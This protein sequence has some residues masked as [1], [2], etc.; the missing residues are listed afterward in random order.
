MVVSAWGQQQSPAN[1]VPNPGFE[2]FAHPPPEWYYNGKDFSRT[3]KYWSSPTGA[4]PDAYGPAVVVPGS[5][6]EKGF[7]DERPRSGQ[8][9]A[10]I[11]VYG[12]D[13][14]KPHC[15]EYLQ[16]RLTEPLVYGQLYEVSFW[17]RKLGRAGATDNLA[18]A[19]AYESHYVPTPDL[20]SHPPVW[21]CRRTA[22]AWVDRWQR[23][24]D[25]IRADGEYRYLLLGNF[26]SDE[27]TTFV[28]ARKDPLAY[29]YYYIDD[30]QV[31]KRPPYLVAPVIPEDLAEVRPEA[32]MV[33][34][35]QTIHFDTD[36]SE[37]LPA[38]LTELNK[39]YQLMTQYPGMAIEVLGHTDNQGGV[40]YNQALS[41]RRA[42]A[43]V[44]YLTS[45][46]V[47]EARIRATGR[48]EH[49]PIAVNTTQ[50]GRKRNRRVEF[51]IR[52]M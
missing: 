19:F 18:V 24:G 8:A 27:E 1:L 17:V 20:L 35:L 5:W 31:I 41:E 3:V 46:G 6:R 42:Q 48:G 30:V 32:G 36:K 26:R 44:H 14:G 38:S 13:S 29:A 40:E 4:S 47:H 28:P 10:G 25:T 23:I 9:M 12:C 45:R 2:E 50:E 49:N 39:L 37:L 16:V 21:E 15:R 33:V 43:V 34:R 52:E 7:G 51:F 11:T 22:G